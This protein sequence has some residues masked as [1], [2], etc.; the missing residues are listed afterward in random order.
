MDMTVVTPDLS[1]VASI[2]NGSCHLR[3]SLASGLDQTG[4]FFELGVIDDGSTDDSGR[5]LDEVARADARVRVVHPDNQGL[6][7]ALMR[8]CGEAPG[9]LI[10]RPDPADLV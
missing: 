2:Y 10:A 9:R 8:G 1:I 3:P 7:R 6:T 5:V 4:V